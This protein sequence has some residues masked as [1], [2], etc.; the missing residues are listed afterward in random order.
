[1]ASRGKHRRP[2]PRRRRFLLSLL[3]VF[4]FL[5]GASECGA[6]GPQRI[7]GTVIGRDFVAWS[8]TNIHYRL[9]VRN[10]DCSTV[11]VR[12][13]FANW[14]RCVK[15]SFYPNCKYVNTKAA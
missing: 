13:P 15:G 2:G 12:E 10:N 4:P 8:E 3:V 9:H 11:W 6:G 7:A 5:L 1:M 14:N